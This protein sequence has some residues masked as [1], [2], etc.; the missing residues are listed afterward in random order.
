MTSAS[1]L[2]LEEHITSF[3]QKKSLLEQLMHESQVSH[4]DE[5]I[6][7]YS[8]QEDVKK[9]I[10]ERIQAISLESMAVIAQGKRQYL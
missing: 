6:A 5:F 3:E 7:W 1:R 10:Y 2:N 9:D 8:E 4:L